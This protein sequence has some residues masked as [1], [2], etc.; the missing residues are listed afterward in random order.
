MTIAHRSRGLDAGIFSDYDFIVA[1]TSREQ[2][3]LTRLKAKLE[4]MHQSRQAE[5]GTGSRLNMERARVVQLGSHLPRKGGEVREILVPLRIDPAVE[6]ELWEN[7]MGRSRRRWKCFY[8][9]RW[10]GSLRSRGVLS[11]CELRSSWLD[12]KLSFDG[13]H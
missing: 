9:K 1:F 11:L 10:D 13:I 7:K 4:A 6:W 2:E 12:S 5:A 8:G 3:N